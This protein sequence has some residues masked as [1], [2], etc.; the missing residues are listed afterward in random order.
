[1][2]PERFR[3][4]VSAVLLLGVAASALLM[5]IGFAGALLVGWNGS[6]VGQPASSV[7]ATDFSHVA[8]GLLALRPIAFAQ[9]GLLVLLA[10]PVLRVTASVVSFGLEGDRIYTA[11]TLTVLVILLTSIFAVR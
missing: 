3:G 8:D 11:V 4:T 10:T 2:S 6:L 7:A 9:G 1:V 5:V